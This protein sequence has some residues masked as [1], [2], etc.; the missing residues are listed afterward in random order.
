MKKVAPWPDQTP[1]HRVHPLATRP[2]ALES[3]RR[4]IGVEC[5]HEAFVKLAA[6]PELASPNATLLHVCAGSQVGRSAPPP[7]IHY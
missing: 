6:M 3:G 7:P 5:L 2:Q 1:P 4:V